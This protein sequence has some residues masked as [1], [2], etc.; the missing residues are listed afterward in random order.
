MNC[1]QCQRTAIYELGGYPLCVEHAMLIQRTNQAFLDSLQR[2]SEQA[3][4]DFAEIAGD[5]GYFAQKMLEE[6]ARAPK[7]TNIT[8]RDSIVGAVNTGTIKSLQVH[9]NHLVNGGSPEVSQALAKLA[10]GILASKLAD[11]QKR[12]AIDQ[13][14]FVASEAAK[15]APERKGLSVLRPVVSSLTAL[16]G[17][18][19]DLTQLWEVYGKT[20]LK[21]LGIG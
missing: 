19:A 17:T 3:R 15:P 16:L 18:T 9:M 5:A 4:A 14:E 13:L 10:N 11:D 20:L 1:S 2:Q 6:Q 7:V 12:E 21:A 8:V